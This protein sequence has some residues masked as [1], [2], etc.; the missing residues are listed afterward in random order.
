MNITEKSI[1][2]ILRYLSQVFPILFLGLIFSCSDNEGEKPES[3]QSIW[4]EQPANNWN[5]AIPIGNGT[6]GGMVYGGI[7]SDTIKINEETLWSG[8]PRNLQNYTAIDYLRQIRKLLLEDRTIEAEAL[9][10]STMLGPN[11]ECYL[12]MG[13]LIIGQ[14]SEGEVM[15]YKR[16]LDLQKGIV[17]VTYSMGYV[18]Y[19]E[20][21]F[22]SFP[23]KAIL[24]G[25]VLTP[26]QGWVSD[27]AES[28]NYSFYV[29]LSS[30]LVV[31]L[32][33][34]SISKKIKR[35]EHT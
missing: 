32:Y 11:N 30:F 1:N 2:S 7:L 8:G 12:P 4:F 21:V 31:F 14:I 24:G 3:N 5:E 17:D 9:I 34:V 10:D 22:A 29:P 35:V 33:D 6:L 28:I 16:W 20:E 18:T 19:K 27:L 23:D 13:E 26:I 15:N 25:A